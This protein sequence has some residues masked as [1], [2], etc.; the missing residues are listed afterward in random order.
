MRSISSTL[1]VPAVRTWSFVVFGDACPTICCACSSV[2]PFDRYAVIHVAR[3]VWQQV[4]GG[5]SAAAARRLIM[6]SVGAVNASNVPMRIST[7]PEGCAACTC[8]DT[9][10]SS[11]ACSCRSAA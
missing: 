6:A 2:P 3:N 11:S 8:A 1:I 9:A 5:R 7:Q 10:T 4:E